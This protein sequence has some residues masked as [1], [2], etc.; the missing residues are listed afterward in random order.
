MLFGLFVFIFWI[1]AS[2]DTFSN[3]LFVQE[4]VGQFGKLFKIYKLKSMQNNSN[5][6]S[7][8]GQFIR[9]SKID[10]LP[11]LFNVLIGDMS[12]VGPR[13]DIAGYYDQL[14]GAN[15][16]LLLLKPGLTSQASIKYFNEESILNSK[17]NPQE[18]ND[19]VIFPDK[20]KMNLDYLKNQSLML[21][22]KIIFKTIFANKKNINQ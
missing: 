13:P 1:A 19:T 9:N 2:I 17:K 6:I 16:N 4:R 20:I 21:D 14:S 8:F 18:Y 15:S 10:E 12:F 5:K 7:R 22:L 3:G 11:Q